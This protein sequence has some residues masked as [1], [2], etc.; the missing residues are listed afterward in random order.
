MKQRSGA[1]AE[2]FARGLGHPRE[3]GPGIGHVAAERIEIRRVRFARRDGGLEP[4]MQ[5][6]VDS[7][8]PGT[9]SE[10]MCRSQVSVGWDGALYDC[11]FNQMLELPV[12]GGARATIWD[13]DDF[14]A[15]T[16]RA[17]ATAEHCYG[18]TAGAGSSCGGALASR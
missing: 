12:A 16:G 13:I 11:D 9:V 4:Y 17:I 8:N 10:L 7:F 1:T 14:S 5:L 2:T 3:E 6:L 15:L 18:C